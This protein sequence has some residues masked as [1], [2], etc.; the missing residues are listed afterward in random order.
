MGPVNLLKEEYIILKTQENTY[1]WN[2][3]FIEKAE[4]NF[5]KIKFLQQ[6]CEIIYELEAKISTETI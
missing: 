4:G 3:L 6:G 2:M 5:K 1:L